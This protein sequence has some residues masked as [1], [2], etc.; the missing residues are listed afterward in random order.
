MDTFSQ[1]LEELVSRDEENRFTDLL[2]SAPSHVL[3]ET[4]GRGRTL[5]MFASEYGDIDR[6]GEVIERAGELGVGED[7]LGMR[8][9]RGMSAP[10]IAANVGQLTTMRLLLDQRPLC[11][12]D[13]NEWQETLL[14]V[15]TAG[16][17]P[18]V[19]AD[20]LRRGD[21]QVDA[22]DKWHQTALQIAQ[23]QKGGRCHSEVVEV[24]REWYEE[25]G[26][27]LP[28]PPPPS[29]T[30]V[31][32]GTTLPSLQSEFLSAVKAR[33]E[34]TLD[35]S[36]ITTKHVTNTALGK[37]QAYLKSQPQFS[38]PARKALSKC[39]EYPADHERVR[40][41][42]MDEAIDPAGR[43]MFGLTAVQKAAAWNDGELLD[44]LLCVLEPG[45][46]TRRTGKQ[47]QHALDI[48]LE[49]GSQTAIKKLRDTGHFG[50][51]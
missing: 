42:V 20:L 39:I 22:E 43:D 35:E 3:L 1:L 50:S 4:D 44:I 5:L 45:D 38:A 26:E 46:I 23:L 16:G 49:Y 10:M 2:M 15:A 37:T 33:G 19:V 28:P 51:Q 40:Q 21:M 17:H 9:K 48:A 6:I 14:H 41:L 13:R 29:M 30:M 31:H 36:A 34:R 11:L 25:R 18:A 27:P 12:A 47:D 7:L 32:D 24:F 8:D